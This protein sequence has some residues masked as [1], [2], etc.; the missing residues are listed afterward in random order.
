[1]AMSSAHPLTTTSLTPSPLPLFLF[2]LLSTHETV[3]VISQ[4]P[5]NPAHR[6]LKRHGYVV[7]SLLLAL[8][9]VTTLAALLRHRAGLLLSAAGAMGLNAWV[10]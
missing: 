2:F 1:M 7:G 10:W 8:P 3:H 5:L 6:I 4:W 9:C